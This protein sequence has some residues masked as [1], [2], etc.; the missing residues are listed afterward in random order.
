M[1]SSRSFER[2]AD[3]ALPA[4]INHAARTP[5][6][7]QLP[8]A[9]VRMSMK[10][11]SAAADQIREALLRSGGSVVD[12]RFLSDRRIK[13]RI[14]SDRQKELLDRL[15]RSGTIVEHPAPPPADTRQLEI[16][17]QW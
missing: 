8:Q 7:L 12:E 17:I 6:G 9:A 3:E 10:D 1:K 4:G 5:T 14:P 16:T 13:G 11:P 2:Q 15:E